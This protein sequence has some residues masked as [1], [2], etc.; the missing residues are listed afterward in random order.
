MNNLSKGTNKAIHRAK[1][2]ASRIKEEEKMAQVKSNITYATTHDR[3][4][5]L[6]LIEVIRDG[7]NREVIGYYSTMAICKVIIRAHRSMSS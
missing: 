3:K 2:I 4:R 6:Y 1:F 5:N 7:V